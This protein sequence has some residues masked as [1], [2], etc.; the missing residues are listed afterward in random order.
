[1][2]QGMLDAALDDFT[3]AVRADPAYP[4]PYYKMA[5]IFEQQGHREQAE[6]ARQKF[7]AL[8]SLREEEVLAKQAQNQLLQVAR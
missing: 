5:Q 8:G 3:A 6:K 1:M 7:T 2:Q 4:L